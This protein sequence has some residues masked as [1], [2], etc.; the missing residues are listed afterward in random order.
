MNHLA[1]HTEWCRARTTIQHILREPGALSARSIE[2]LRVAVLPQI[3][4]ALIM[5]AESGLSADAL[6][7]WHAFLPA[8]VAAVG[9]DPEL[10]RAEAH[11]RAGLAALTQRA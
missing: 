6:R 2:L 4:A 5:L 10:A 7:R 1:T 9:P 8:A 11:L 3:E